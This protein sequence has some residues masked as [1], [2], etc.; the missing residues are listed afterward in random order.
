MVLVWLDFAIE[1]WRSKGGVDD[2]GAKD[3]RVDRKSRGFALGG[4]VLEA[5]I[6]GGGV[7]RECLGGVRTTGL[8]IAG[9]GV[10]AG[11]GVRWWLCLW[12]CLWLWDL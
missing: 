8:E 9:G 3:W 7:A 1:D 5:R 10:C 12:L 11:E 6:C 2:T 4:T